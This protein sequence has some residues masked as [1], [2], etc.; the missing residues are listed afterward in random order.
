MSQFISNADVRLYSDMVHLEFYNKGN[1]LRGTTRMRPSVEGE[2]VTFPVMGAGVASPHIPRTDVTPMSPNVYQ[3]ICPLLDWDAADYVDKFELAKIN[4]D[5]VSEIVQISVEAI[6]RQYDQSEID[7]LTAS[8]TTMIIPPNAENLTY[9]KILEAIGELDNNGVPANDRYCAITV[10]GQTAL[11][12]DE[13]FISNR[14]T[15]NNLVE[16]GSINGVSVLGVKFIVIPDETIDNIT[17]GLPI[18]GDIRTAFMW[19]MQSMGMATGVG[20]DQTTTVDWVTEKYSWLVRT[21]L[22][23]GAVAIDA[24]GIVEI[25]Y[26]QTA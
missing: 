19:Q 3:V 13:R 14:Y 17:F 18:S 22:S 15:N 10:S 25:D 11:L 9:A 20:L 2:S 1:R 12:Q 8:G 16:K 6:G 23:V 24:R 4:F 7:A 26:D 5:E 21:V